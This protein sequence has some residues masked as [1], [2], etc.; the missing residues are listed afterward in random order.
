MAVFEELENFSISEWIS[1]SSIL[2]RQITSPTLMI[3]AKGK[4]QRQENNLNNYILISNNDCIQD[5]DGRRY[6]ILDIST[7]YIKNE[8]YF[9]RHYTCFN[10]EV[11]QAFL[12]I[13][14]KLTRII[15]ILKPIPLQKANMIQ[16]QNASI[17]FLNF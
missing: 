10:D 16:F 17:M 2:K 9:K 6:F 13:Y 5:D 11:G 4:D 8:E 15:S 1:I 3:E 12:V 14:M 7:K